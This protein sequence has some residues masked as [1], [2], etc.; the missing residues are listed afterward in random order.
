MISEMALADT[1]S[2]NLDR[3]GSAALGAALAALEPLFDQHGGDISKWTPEAYRTLV[4]TAI[5]SGVREA[6][7]RTQAD[8]NRVIAG[9]DVIP[10]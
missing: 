9:F 3:H 2:V 7:N 10:Y 5:V 4:W 8:Y 6:A 1:M